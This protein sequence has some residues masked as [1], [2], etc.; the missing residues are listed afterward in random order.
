MPNPHGNLAGFTDPEEEGWEERVLQ[1]VRARK[2]KNPGAGRNRRDYMVKVWFDDPFRL[3]LDEAAKRR[4]ITLSG[5]TRRA[6]AAFVAKDLGIPI[7]EVLK[8][9]SKPT[10][11]G[12][13]YP[14]PGKPIR[15]VD[16][17]EGYGDWVI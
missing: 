8:H 10:D 4:N 13:A 9:A 3:L 5:Y 6:L 16:D 2:R 17:G 15:S 7:T 12:T 14:R 1:R 11:Y